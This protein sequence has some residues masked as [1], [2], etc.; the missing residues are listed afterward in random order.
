MA[1]RKVALVTGGATG[2]GKS[3]VLALARAGYDVAINY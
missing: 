1:S 3:A 2:I